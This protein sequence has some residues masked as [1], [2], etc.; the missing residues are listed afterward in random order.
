MKELR[1]RTE[2]DLAVVRHALA[3]VVVRH[4]GKCRCGWCQ[5]SRELLERVEARL[6]VVA[7]GRVQ[8]VPVQAKRSRSKGRRR[9]GPRGEA[10][11]A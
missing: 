10:F 3:A 9:P 4:F 11:G 2:Q 7:V 1:L 6:P 5:S 8:V